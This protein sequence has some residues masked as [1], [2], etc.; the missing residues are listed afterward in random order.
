MWDIPQDRLKNKPINIKGLDIIQNMFCDDSGIT[1]ATTIK[2]A[3]K[4][5]NEHY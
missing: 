4:A 3:W 2:S 5:D 1:L